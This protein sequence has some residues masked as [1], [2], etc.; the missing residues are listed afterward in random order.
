MIMNKGLLAISVCLCCSFLFSQDDFAAA[1][2]KFSRVKK[3]YESREQ[4]LHLLLKEKT[5]EFSKP[6]IILVA[7]KHEG[8]LKVYARNFG[9]GE[10]QLLFNYDICAKSGVLGP[11]RKQGDLQVPEGLYHID[12]FNPASSFH[13]SLGI[14]YPN[15]SDRIRG[16]AENLGG[17]IFIHG[18][19]ATIGCL[20]MTNP[21]IEQLYVLAVQA[22]KAGQKKIPVYIFP[23]EMKA[24]NNILHGKKFPEHKKLWE[25]LHKAYTKFELKPDYISFYIQKDGSYKL[26]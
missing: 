16:Q 9:I 18:E 5:I 15:A 17:D 26:N 10:F 24:E 14:N 22:K 2:K 3:A 23:Y 21:I 13:L 7:L 4:T 11:K 1:Q 25:E 8:L 12:R 20:P 19:C 6:E